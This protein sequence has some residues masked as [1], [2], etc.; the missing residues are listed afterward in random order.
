MRPRWPLVLAAAAALLALAAPAAAGQSVRPTP[1]PDPQAD[2]RAEQRDLDAARRAVER[3]RRDARRAR[4]FERNGA[5]DRWLRDRLEAERGV[6][7]DTWE[8]FVERQR[9]RRGSAGEGPGAGLNQRLEEQW[10]GQRERLRER[11]PG[12]L[13]PGDGRGLLRR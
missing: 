6:G 8:D 10:R 1:R 5:W 9:P 13:R 7:P 11:G 12:R 2:W 4:E 3:Q